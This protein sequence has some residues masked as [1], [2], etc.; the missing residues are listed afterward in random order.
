MM[1]QH[2]FSSILLLVDVII[3]RLT[4]TGFSLQNLIL[5]GDTVSYAEN[6]V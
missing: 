3:K 4:S 5:F 1:T 6:Y 2:N